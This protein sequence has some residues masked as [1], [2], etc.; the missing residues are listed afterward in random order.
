MTYTEIIDYTYALLKQIYYSAIE[1]IVTTIFIYFV[2]IYIYIYKCIIA[3]I[4]NVVNK[5][6]IIN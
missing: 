4:K 2:Y 3:I 5:L 1:N 6:K